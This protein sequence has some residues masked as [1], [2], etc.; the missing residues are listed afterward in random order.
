MISFAVLTVVKTTVVCGVALLLSRLCRRTR[1]SIRH[2]MFV[3]TFAALIAVPSIATV[4][5]TI[6][7]TVP[8]LATVEPSSAEN[9][10]EGC[11]VA[12]PVRLRELPYR[13]SFNN[14][15][16]HAPFQSPS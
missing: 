3:L 14:R 1:A 8:V 15:R 12:Q 5:S 10:P 9:A 7:V 13:R 11:P 6:A 2:V 4:I 16:G